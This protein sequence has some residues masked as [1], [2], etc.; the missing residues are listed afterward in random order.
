VSLEYFQISLIKLVQGQRDENV[1]TSRRR[2]ELTALE[3]EWL[4]GIRTARGFDLTVRIQ[5]RWRE[6]RVRIGAPLTTAALG[7]RLTTCMQ[8]YLS[9]SVG[10]SMF[11]HGESVRFIDFVLRKYTDECVLQSVCHWE[12]AVSR[13]TQGPG[14]PDE[15]EP[16]NADVPRFTVLSP[17]PLADIVLFC[18]SPRAVFDRLSR[19]ETLPEATDEEHYMLV[20]PGL[21][22]LSRTATASEADLFRRCQSVAWRHPDQ[23]T[24]ASIGDS[25]RGL[26]GAG[27]LI[28]EARDTG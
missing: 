24:D 20:A 2:H 22:R 19:G 12:R 10:T 28:A 4:Q 23:T 1:L 11:F 13:L 15:G 27:A 16:R 26:W 8:E 25:L 7:C 9:E 18:C 6:I 5:R 3:V 21:E 17:H 14:L